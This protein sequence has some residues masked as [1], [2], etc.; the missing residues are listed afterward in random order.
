MVWRVIAD[1]AAFWSEI[2]CNLVSVANRYKR[3]CAVRVPVCASENFQAC[4]KCPLLVLDIASEPGTTGSFACGAKPGQVS[5]L[6][7]HLLSGAHGY[8]LFLT[9]EPESWTF[10][11][12][13]VS[14]FET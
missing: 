6:Y 3:R 7:P 9:P 14:L 13:S 4:A 2:S 5:I 12:Y 10:S 8:C 11:V 1:H